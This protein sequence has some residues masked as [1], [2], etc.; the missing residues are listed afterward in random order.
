MTMESL[1]CCGTTIHAHRCSVVTRASYRAREVATRERR[2]EGR[3]HTV[4]DVAL[5]VRQLLQH[6]AVPRYHL[7]HRIADD[8]EH[9]VIVAQPAAPEL[10]EELA[11]FHRSRMQ[12]SVAARRVGGDGEG[13]SRRIG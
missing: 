4:R 6:R 13:V 11:A 3:A 10:R 1:R 8:V 2:A 12:E 7:R 5:P 9:E